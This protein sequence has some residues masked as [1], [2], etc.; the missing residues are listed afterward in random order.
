MAGHWSFNDGTG[1]TAADS[2]GNGYNATLFNGV[3]WINGVFGGA[4]SA[5]N[6]NQYVSTPTI[7]LTGTTA[8]TVSMWV[9][10][11]YTS[12][13]TS[14][15]T[16]YEFSSSING[17]TGTF[18]LY[19]DE[20]ADCGT[21][22][23]ELGLRGDAG[24]NLKC[25]AQPTSGVWH[26]LAVVYDVTQAAANEVTLYID[27]V[28]QTPLSQTHSADNTAAFGNFPLYLFSRA[29]TT[30]FSGG[31]MD[32]FQLYSRAL[33]ST[34]VQEI[35][36]EKSTVSIGA[37]VAPTSLAF[38]NQSVNTTSTPLSVILSS[39][40]TNPLVISNITTTGDFAFPSNTCTGLPMATPA[41]CTLNVTYT[42]TVSGAETG[43]LI[44]SSKR[45]EQSH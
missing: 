21:P 14:G 10:R 9:N 43:S 11:T 45:S 18:A 3:T 24:F 23:M 12:G 38:G 37:A 39:V 25:Y 28:L 13:G 33:S 29:G 6:V 30:S 7:N 35:Y 8:V 20:A 22:A 26:H 34:E 31:E 2:S 15:T 44:I 27:G 40:G 41:S 1:T 42:P 17:N 4:I 5:N 32:E 36:N 19:P 16:L